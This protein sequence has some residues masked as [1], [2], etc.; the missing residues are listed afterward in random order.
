MV[1]ALA[2]FGILLGLAF[3][4]LIVFDVFQWRAKRTTISQYL[5]TQTRR[6]PVLGVAIGFVVGFLLGNLGGHL[7]FPQYLP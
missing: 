7:F 2:T 5:L 4:G 1:Y 6:W 3:S